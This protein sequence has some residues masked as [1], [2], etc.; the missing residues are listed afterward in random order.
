LRNTW[1]LKQISNFLK[2]PPT[3]ENWKPSQKSRK[4]QLKLFF[5]RSFLR[6]MPIPSLNLNISNPE[7]QLL[8]E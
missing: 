5:L 4:M 7:K 2:F 3:P 8:E 6:K 1:N